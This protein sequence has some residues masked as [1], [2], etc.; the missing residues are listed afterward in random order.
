M[1]VNITGAKVLFTIPVFGGIPIT[2]TI[3]NTWIVMAA[4]VAVCIF[5]TRNM[6]VHAT[7][8]RQIIAEYL[9]GMVNNLVRENM[10][11]QFMG[12]VP[13]IGALFSL[14]MFCSLSSLFG[15]YA[16]TGDLSTCAGWALLAFVMITY[17]K[18]RTQKL[19]GYLKSFTEPIF[20]M[21]PL[22]LI[23]ECA[24]P[25]SMAFRHFGNIASGA[26]VT[27]LVYAALA[28]LSTAVL[29]LLPGALGTLLSGIPIF[30]IGI[31]AVLSIY[32]DLFSSVLQAFIFCMLTMMYIKLACES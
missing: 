29:G 26:V 3:V 14:S 15:M 8:K 9:V 2:E 24:T 4:I 11:E 10:G 27:A 12:Y 32:F 20:V 7:S 19:G 16:P 21:T 13:F 31:P 1:N 23:S 22:N 28:S 25:L 5:L 30:Q 18:I 17:Y 6:K